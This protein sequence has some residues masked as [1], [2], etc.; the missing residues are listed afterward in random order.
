MPDTVLVVPCYNEADRLDADAFRTFAAGAPEVRVLFV[1][2][3]SSDGTAAILDSL[4][5][6]EPAFDVLHLDRNSGKAEAVRRGIMSALETR[7]AFVGFWDADLSTPLDEF[8]G[9]RAVFDDRPEIE[10]VFG[11]RVNLL[12]RSIR[13]KLVRHYIGRVFATVVATSLR[14]PIYDTQCGA[15]LFRVGAGVAGLFD[16]PF[17]SRWIFDVEI[18]ARSIAARRGTDLPPVGAIIYEQPLMSWY[19]VQGSKLRLR[20]FAIVARDFMRIRRTYVRARR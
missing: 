11:S 6:D 16:T 13:R 1:N 17:L 8:A 7:P 10:M 12:G 3:G 5:G 9:M 14:L 20:D 18:I 15:K 2:D 4:C 19:D